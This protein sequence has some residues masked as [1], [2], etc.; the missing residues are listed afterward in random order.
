MTQSQSKFSI[1]FFLM[2]WCGVVPAG[3]L[4]VDAASEAAEPDGLRWSTGF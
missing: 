3:V 1:F 2:L 4:Y